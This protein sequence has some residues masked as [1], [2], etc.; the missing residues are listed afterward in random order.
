MRLSCTNF[1]KHFL[2][3]KFQQERVITSNDTSPKIAKNS[4]CQ[5]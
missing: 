3:S 4:L 2:E 1:S 5:N